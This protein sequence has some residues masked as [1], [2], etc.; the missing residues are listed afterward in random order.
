MVPPFGRVE[1]EGPCGSSGSLAR[2]CPPSEPDRWAM[3][4]VTTVGS[5]DHPPPACHPPPAWNWRRRLDVLHEEPQEHDDPRGAAAPLRVIR[6][7]LKLRE[8]EAKKPRKI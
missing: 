2:T 8:Q 4:L 1:L 3:R 6:S 7:S 5:A